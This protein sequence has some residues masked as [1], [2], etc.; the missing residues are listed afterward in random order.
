MK[1][2]YLLSSVFTLV[3]TLTFAQS[4]LFKKT[5]ENISRLTVNDGNVIKQKTSTNKA[6]GDTVWSEDFG[7]GFPAGWT[8]V[9]NNFQGLNWR[10]ANQ[11][12][13]DNPA[14]NGYTTAYPTIPSTTN[15]NG[16]MLLFSDSLNWACVGAGTCVD[17]DSYFQTAAIPIGSAGSYILKFQTEYRTCCAGGSPEFLSLRVSTDSTFP[18]T[19]ATQTWEVKNTPH[20]TGSFRNV[21]VN[22]SAI[23]V[24][25]PYVYIR[26]HKQN[27]SHYF[28][29]I[30]DLAITEGSTDDI[31]LTEASS[32]FWY[33]GGGHYTEVP[34]ML[35]ANINF[36]GM[37]ENFG[38][39]AQTNVKM[40]VTGSGPN[41]YS[42]TSNII[43][44]LPPLSVDTLY[45]TVSTTTWDLSNALTGTNT[46]DFIASQDET[47]E[48]PGDN[49]IT[50][51]TFKTNT[52]GNNF[53]KLYSR[54]YGTPTSAIAPDQW[55][56][57]NVDGS[58]I[59]LI[60]TLPTTTVD[61]HL[62]IV[63][64]IEVYI[65]PNADVSGNA[66]MIAHVEDAATTPGD[67]Q[68]A[69]PVASSDPT[70]ITTNGGWVNFPLTDGSGTPQPHVVTAD[71][72]YFV[73]VEM[74]GL[75]AGLNMDI[76]EDENSPQSDI[77]TL[78]KLA[79]G[80]PPI[81]WGG[82]SG[83]VPMIRLNCDFYNGTEDL[84]NDMNFSV[85]PNPSAGEFNVNLESKTASAVDL[86]VRNVVGQ[87]VMIKEVAVSGSTKETISLANYDKGVYFLTINNNG[88][89]KTV[90]LIVE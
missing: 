6:V 62:V 57:G 90:K 45:D 19:Q 87:T 76:G 81:L 84:T 63:R 86:T 58:K 61:G 3:A 39:A 55:V 41:A 79:G 4:D 80:T 71:G 18:N 82:A 24:G 59:A 73:S 44:S 50:G 28:W 77:Q 66:I 15:A 83:G 40:D 75:T 10:Y 65:S 48:N 89:T 1:K 51:R 13:L 78:I 85:Y 37:I 20:S 64:S 22:I 36:R 2:I 31:L 72:D 43:A 11:P 26:F 56:N 54:D 52:P 30:D 16:F 12:L 27:A 60:Y 33:Q 35:G 34:G 7:G 14:P 70:P 74:Y 23:A 29:E 32:D 21:E 8:V 53:A 69:V 47:D 46:I 17:M 25:A 38:A 9:D 5:N 42:S 68:N 88:E 49:M 67:W